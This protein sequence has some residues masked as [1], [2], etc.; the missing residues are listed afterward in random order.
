MHVG[1]IETDI[2]LV[3]RLLAGQFP[4]WANK[5]I[6][7]I[8]SVGTDHDIYRLDETL[9]VRLPPSAGL[10]TKLQRKHFGLLNRRHHSRWQSQYPLRSVL[11][12]ATILTTGLFVNGCQ[13]A[14]LARLPSL[15]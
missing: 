13:A 8:P 6:E 5:S 12:Q 15:T 9:V 4:K 10:G 11:L 14:M 2:T 1:E 7:F 3:R